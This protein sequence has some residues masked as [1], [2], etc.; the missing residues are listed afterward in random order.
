MPQANFS[1]GTRHL[2]W[3]R[4]N[5]E[6]VF[7]WCLVWFF[8]L[9]N[10]LSKGS[11]VKLGQ[12]TSYCQLGKTGNSSW[13]I[14]LLCL[15]QWILP[16]NVPLTLIRAEVAIPTY[17]RVEMWEAREYYL[18]SS[19]MWFD[20]FRTQSYSAYQSLCPP[21]II[22]LTHFSLPDL[23]FPLELLL[24][25]SPSALRKTHQISNISMYRPH[26]SSNYMHPIFTSIKMEKGVGGKCKANSMVLF[27]LESKSLVTVFFVQL[28]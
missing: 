23:P 4:P 26:P 10:A 7:T 20:C 27:I 28:G 22:T 16:I 15:L 11:H 14:S 12:N 3:P 5:K 1:A 17:V 6:L 21:A 2:V 24:I 8:F 9:I 19:S 13:T 25:L 18:I